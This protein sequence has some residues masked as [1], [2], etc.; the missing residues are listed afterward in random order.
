M[1]RAGR[2]SFALK[3]VQTGFFLATLLW[4]ALLPIPTAASEPNP[5]PGFTLESLDGADVS[6]EQFRGQYLV[7]NFWATWCGPCKM[8][9]PSLEA[10]HQTF[11]SKNL[12]LLA[13]SG[14]MFGAQVVR[15]FVEAHN[16]TFTVL[17][18]PA[19]KVSHKFG[20]VSLPTTYL[21][22]PDG[23]IIGVSQGAE[24]W[25]SPETLQYFQELLKIN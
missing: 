24:N 21:V 19:L 16:L 2:L 4:T 1:H 10:L 25:A 5:A 11:K 3:R 6:L 22:G 18:D 15:P 17:L 8:E 9:M 13:V 7:I 12:K 20:V 14:D 23:N